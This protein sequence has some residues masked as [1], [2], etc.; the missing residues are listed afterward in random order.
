MIKVIT[1]K[2]IRI[3]ALSSTQDQQFLTK[4]MI[5]ILVWEDKVDKFRVQKSAFSFLAFDRTKL[6]DL[7]DFDDKQKNVSHTK[8]R[9][10][11]DILTL[12]L[13][14]LLFGKSYV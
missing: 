12:T 8:C 5:E 2:V 10:S 1:R 11:R 14:P 6:V 9:L 3:L 13:N 7:C 4:F